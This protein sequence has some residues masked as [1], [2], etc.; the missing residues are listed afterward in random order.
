MDCEEDDEV[1]RGRG[2]G[3]CVMT[4]FQESVYISRESAILA[5]SG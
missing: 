5:G 2:V 3:S 1:F 4:L